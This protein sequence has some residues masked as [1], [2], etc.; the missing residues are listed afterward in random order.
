MMRGAA[1]LALALG[2]CWR[3][4]FAGAP[5][6]AI[7]PVAALNQGLTALEKNAAQP[8]RARYDALAPVIDQAFDLP[9]ILKTIVGLRWPQIPP[10]QQQALLDVFRSYT[11]CNYVGNFNADSG[12]AFRT[13][14]ASRA[15]GADQVVETEIV[16]KSGDPVRI[17]YVMRQTASGSPNAAWKA[18]DVLEDSSISQ[19]AVQRSDFRA[20]LS[21]GHA[22]ALI[23]SLKGKIATLSGGTIKS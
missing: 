9:Q 4:A 5:E 7:A 11:I 22:D 13:L 23:A 18:V 16:P 6:A 20:L 3:P 10:A 12:D 8:F 19:A 15:V 21:G 17:D 1:L 2:C 14:P